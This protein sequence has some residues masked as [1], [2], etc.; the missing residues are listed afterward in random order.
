[1]PSSTLVLLIILIFFYRKDCKKRCRRRKNPEIGIKFQSMDNFNE[2]V[3]ETILVQKTA[4]LHE[5][6][7]SK[8]SL[9]SN[10]K[11]TCIVTDR[12]SPLPPFTTSANIDTPKNDVSTVIEIPELSSPDASFT[13]SSFSDVLSRPS[14]A[15]GT[16]KS[17]PSLTSVSSL[18][19]STQ[20]EICSSSTS[21]T[22]INEQS[23][24]L[25]SEMYAHSPPLTSVAE[26]SVTPQLQIVTEV[27]MS[28]K[29]SVPV[30]EVSLSVEPDVPTDSPTSEPATVC[31]LEAKL[32]SPDLS[33]TSNAGC[34]LNVMATHWPTEP[35]LASPMDTSPKASPLSH[36][37]TPKESSCIDLFSSES[38]DMSPSV[39]IKT[40]GSSSS[41][42][43][44]KAPVA[45]TNEVIITIEDDDEERK[46]YRNEKLLMENVVNEISAV[47]EVEKEEEGVSKFVKTVVIDVSDAVCKNGSGIVKALVDTVIDIPAE[48]SVNSEGEANG[49]ESFF[50]SIPGV[51]DMEEDGLLQS[52]VKEKVVSVSGLNSVVKDD[53]PMAMKNVNRDVPG[54]TDYVADKNGADVV[55]DG[56]EVDVPGLTNAD[57][58]G[59]NED[60]KIGS[61]CSLKI[62]V[63]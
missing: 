40:N 12:P 34:T 4:I 11:E 15:T 60:A 43:T 19:L 14:S 36:P 53:L 37:A 32:S 25:A 27:S 18:S 28:T 13:C 7:R 39:S 3:S 52:V 29:A 6:Q 31:A 38:S 21:L 56:A 9:D 59:V 1:M 51:K 55:T 45:P 62:G 26:M 20:P 17:S 16:P 41:T 35:T 50:D 61:G 42:D 63:Y 2:M 30:S 49:L 24:T 5:K 48:V 58:K 47:A 8:D 23:L 46:M 57:A 10:G 33:S 54:V 44:C 22:S